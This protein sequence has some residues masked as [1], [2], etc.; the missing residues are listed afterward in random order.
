[1]TGNTGEKDRIYRGCLE[2]MPQEFQLAQ[3]YEDKPQS[4]LIAEHFPDT[5]QEPLP[6]L[7]KDFT[8]QDFDRPSASLQTAEV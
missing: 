4:Y 2:I 5:P 8:P 3:Y 7:E 6:T 1:M